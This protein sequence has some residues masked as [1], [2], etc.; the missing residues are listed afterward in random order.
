MKTKKA[1]K[2]KTLSLASLPWREMT[3]RERAREKESNAE[4]EA[5][6]QGKRDRN[7]RNT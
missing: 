4:T 6:T 7:P 3:E 5:Q 2:E 1:T